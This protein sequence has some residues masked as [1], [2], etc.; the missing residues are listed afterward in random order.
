MP[1]PGS[2]TPTT[3]HGRSVTGVCTDLAGSTRLLNGHSS[4]AFG[5]AHVGGAHFAFVDGSVR[6]I[7]ESI[8]PITYGRLAQRNDG[9]VVESY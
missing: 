4:R 2:I 5:S 6:L 7:I 1:R 9:G 8:D 3:Q